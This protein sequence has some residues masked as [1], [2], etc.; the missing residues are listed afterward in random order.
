MAFGL[1][2]AQVNAFASQAFISKALKNPMKAASVLSFFFNVDYEDPSHV[3]VMKSG[4]EMLAMFPYW[5][6]GAKE[7][8]VLCQKF[9]DAIRQTGRGAF[10]DQEEWQSTAD[11]KMAQIILCDQLSRNA[12]RGQEEAFAFDEK[13]LDVAR[14]LSKGLVAL[15]PQKDQDIL[16]PDLA[17]LVYPP[18]LQ[19]VISPLMHSELLPD[20]ELAMEVADFS[21]E[22]APEHLRE[23]F[24]GTKAFELEHK[25]VVEQFGRYPHRN[26]NLGRESTPEELEWLANEEELPGWA[27]SQG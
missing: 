2:A 24:E 16:L 13:G 20:H 3:E 19:F 26:A 4:S 22:V 14:D 7:Y 11:G 9:Q 25:V 17:G 23:Q 18:Y 12:F 10:D 21:I 5:Y 8:D 1:T 27:K 6:G 15:E